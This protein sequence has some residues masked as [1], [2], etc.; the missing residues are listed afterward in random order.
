MLGALDASEVWRIWWQTQSA[1]HPYNACLTPLYPE[2]RILVPAGV[3]ESDMVSR[4]VEDVNP[5]ES[6]PPT[7]GSV[8]TVPEYRRDTQIFFPSVA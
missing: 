4:I 1:E 7:V 5:N 6:T 3:A 2:F 8:A